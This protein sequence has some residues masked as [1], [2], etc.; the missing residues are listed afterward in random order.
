M[1]TT[2]LDNIRD[3]LACIPANDRELW[4]R[5][6]MALQSE[7]PGADGL[8]IFDAWSEGVD[9]YD[10]RAVRDT[11][12]SFKP[13]RVTLGTLWHE[14]K[15]R[16]FKGAAPS[17]ETAAETER[18]K[19]E[20]EQR[21]AADEAQYRAR[22][23][24]AQRDAGALWADALPMPP[25]GITTYPQH[26]GVGSHGL[27]YLPDGVA[28]VP[29]R[30]V[31]GELV[32]LQRITPTK[33]T[34]EE[35]R[36]GVREKRFLP[37]GRKSG[38]WHLIGDA[39]GAPVLVFAEG[40]STGA[41]VHEATGRP[42]VVAFDAGNLRP[43]AEAVATLYPAARL[44]F[45][46]DDDRE[47]EARTGTNPGRIKAT[48][49]ARAL[50]GL[51]V[52]PEGLPEAAGSDFNDLDAHAGADAVRAVVERAAGEL[53]AG[54]AEPLPQRAKRADRKPSEA[55]QTRAAAPADGEVPPGPKEPRS[56]PP[57]AA[58]ALLDRFTING[59]GV[60]FTEHDQDGR[61]RAPM[62][63]CSYLV[64]TAR[65]RD[66]DGD[67]WG[68][69]LV[70]DDP[71]GKPR[72][73]AMPARL[74]ASDGAEY[75]AV[76]LSMGLRI[77]SGTKAR[78][79]LTLYLQTRQP[80]EIAICVERTGWHN[81][82]FVLPRET[83]QRAPE[84]GEDAPDRIVY[85]TDGPTENPFRV[86]G[87]LAGW[88]DNVATLC[89]GNS[90]LLFAVSSAFAAFLLRASG[91][92]SGGFNL[93]GPSS[94]GKSTV[95]LVGASVNGGPD[96]MQQ[97]RQTE[98]FLEATAGLHCDALLILDELAQMDKKT[99]GTALY[100]LANG[101]GKGRAT[102][103]GQ[104][105]ARLTW[106]LLFLSTSEIPVA[107]TMAEAGQRI[108]AGQEL[109]MVDIPAEVAPGTAFNTTHDFDGGAVFSLHLAKVCRSYHG[110]A[111]RAFLAWLVEHVD[112]LRDRTREAV[113]RLAARW[114]PDAA[115]GQVHRVVRRFALVAV[116]GEMATE[117]GITGWQPGAATAAAEDCFRDWLNS[118]AAGIG[119]SETTTMRAQVRRFLESH[120][121]GRFTWWHRAADDH[122][123]NTL[124]RAGFRRL[125]T[126]EG[127]SIDTNAQH[128]AE[129]GDK[130]QPRD[131]EE[132]SVEY[133]VLA[134]V[135]RS[136]VCEGF[137]YQAV[138]R[139]LRDSGDLV[140]GTSGRF[141]H[142]ARLP[143]LGMATCYR[144]RPSI[145]EAD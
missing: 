145:F 73:W 36:R 16:G 61:A 45:A 125:V 111:G 42:V 55:P 94:C 103:G 66:G 122:A 86:R 139:V 134:E 14:A 38:C 101:V 123:P 112:E 31:A 133:F 107:T 25:E 136:E 67:S 92:N 49:A 29:V 69:L 34:A 13:G 76:L 58:P 39:M 57:D 41:S 113:E 18:K 127:K 137:D 132:T 20:R 78:S 141:D 3:A 81:R 32:N 82:A 21:R 46:G 75:R 89:V 106:I 54:A 71:A 47:T 115:S 9:T 85:Q 56:G 15:A 72:T 130:M 68:Y 65:T 17:P 121:A 40:Y 84:E 79:L 77:A 104:A 96:Y 124:M 62:W 142:R 80:A 8:A 26:K 105:R 93:Y 135:F 51:A 91:L 6:G 64:V 59:D 37:G 19:R 12:K 28:L 120:G 144:I 7:Y 74:L 138:C 119:N 63:V 88:R 23:D 126:A 97:W 95:L 53:L 27:R 99:V 44:L 102:R 10:A 116:G 143:G 60:F 100:M 48:A 1:P 11:W 43:V 35:E 117:A 98:N 33:P 110:S 24:K 50:G 109:R 128:Q 87:A 5:I 108:H 114:V 129:F 4:L 140:P 70:F 131:G 83:L 52:F 22:A 30:N 118:R 90:R 2:T